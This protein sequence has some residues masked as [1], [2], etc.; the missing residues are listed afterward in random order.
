[1]AFFESSKQQ[2]KRLIVGMNQN[3][4]KAFNAFYKK[5][6]TKL[7]NFAR[8]RGAKSNSYAEDYATDAVLDFM[9]KFGGGGDFDHEKGS[10]FSYLCKMVLNMILNEK[11]DNQPGKIEPLPEN[12]EIADEGELSKLY[13]EIDR[14]AANAWQPIKITLKVVVE[15]IR[16]DGVFEEKCRQLYAFDYPKLLSFNF[17]GSV[18]EIYEGEDKSLNDEKISLMMS[19]WSKKGEIPPKEYNE[20]LV[21]VTRNRCKEKLKKALIAAGYSL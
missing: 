17:K 15:F 10:V 13:D 19:E 16:K 3:D 8:K 21:R 11:R 9:L 18:R 12:G 2:D 20:N 4:G 7:K 6:Y 5:Y 14:N 1:M